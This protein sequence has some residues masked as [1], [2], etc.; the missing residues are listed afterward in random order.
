MC[1]AS[2][3]PKLYPVDRHSF[4]EKVFVKNPD[5][6]MQLSRADC[7][8][9]MVDCIPID[10]FIGLKTL[11]SSSV[12][13]HQNILSEGLALKL[14]HHPNRLYFGCKFWTGRDPFLSYSWV[15]LF[16]Q[17]IK[18]SPSWAKETSR[19]FFHSNLAFVRDILEIGFLDF[20]WHQIICSSLEINN[21]TT[22]QMASWDT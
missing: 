18:K 2:L 20:V 8:T 7:S 14:S 16:V 1:K 5:Q 22:P 15:H 12:G 21:V 6:C 3:I 10:L 11:T 13:A 9:C 19:S 4:I 17:G